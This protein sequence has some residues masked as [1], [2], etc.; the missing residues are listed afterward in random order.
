MNEQELAKFGEQIK[1]QGE[2]QGRTMMDLV[3]DP[4][5]GDFSRVSG[6]TFTHPSLGTVLDSRPSH[7]SSHLTL[8]Y[9]L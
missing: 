2:K 9:C 5:S 1:E 3:F 6:G 7:G 8:C 4:I